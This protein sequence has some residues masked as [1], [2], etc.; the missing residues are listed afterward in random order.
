[1]LIV[2]MVRFVRF[3][4]FLCPLDSG[5]FLMRD[6][7]HNAA[8][9][10]SPPSTGE[11]LQQCST[12]ERVCSMKASH[13]AVKVMCVCVCSSFGNKLRISAD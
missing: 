4:F 1:M 11:Q 7:R 10:R 3:L 2:W 12:L 9:R 5:A 8:R 13:D 6:V